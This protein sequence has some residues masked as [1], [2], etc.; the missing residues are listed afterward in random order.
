[1]TSKLLYYSVLVAVAS[2][3]FSCSPKIVATK[4]YEENE[5]VLDKIEITYKELSKDRPFAIAFTAKDF[6]TVSV[7]IYTDTLKYIY[8][9]EVDE[10]RLADTLTAYNLNAPKV[11]KLIGMMQSIRSTWIKNLDY[12]VDGKKNDVVF[13]SIKPVALKAPL[14]YQ[15][16]YILA[17]FNQPQQFDS[18]GR[19]LD[20]KQRKRLRKINGEAFS[21]I[22]DKVCYAVSGNFR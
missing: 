2:L 18:K 7:E 13:L 1:M 17:Y 19:L 8:D 11:I 20:K 9:F 5:K 16:Y 15:K 14:S 10:P 6:K 3:L 22:N 21:R 12:Y 4:F